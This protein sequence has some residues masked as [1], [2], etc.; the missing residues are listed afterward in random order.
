MSVLNLLQ[1]VKTEQNNFLAVY[2]NKN[3]LIFLV[4]HHFKWFLFNIPVDL[5]LLA[6][7]MLW[8]NYRLGHNHRIVFYY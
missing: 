2:F 6:T 1:I 8:K 5:I 3:V 7:I 4:L